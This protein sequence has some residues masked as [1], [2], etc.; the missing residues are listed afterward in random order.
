MYALNKNDF[1]IIFKLEASN[2]SYHFSSFKNEL[3]GKI[4]EIQYKN[5]AKKG[6]PV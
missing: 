2:I 1:E 4:I 5:K 3:V 6:R